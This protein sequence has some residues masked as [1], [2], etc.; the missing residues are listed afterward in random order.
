MS[1]FTVFVN[2]THAS[3]L[4]Y[5]VMEQTSNNLFLADKNQGKIYVFNNDNKGTLNKVITVGSA[6]TSMVIYNNYLLV[7]LSQAKKIKVIDTS[8]LTEVGEINT[9]K[10]PYWL[11]LDGDK[12][13]STVSRSNGTDY[14]PFIAELSIANNTVVAST[15]TVWPT[16]YPNFYMSGN[17]HI[18]VNP[19]THAAYIGNLGYSPDNIKKYDTSDINNIQYLMQN[20]HGSLGSNGQQFI[21][22]E[23]YSKIYFSASGSDGYAMQIV[24]SDNLTK[25]TDL[26]LGSYPNSV[27]YD[28]NYIYAGK[29]AYYNSGDIKVYNK[30]NNTFVKD[31]SLPDHENL[32]SKGISSGAN[33]YA[34]SNKYLYLLDKNSSKVTKIYD[35]VNN[36]VVD[37]VLVDTALK[38]GDL[39]KMENSSAI[40]QLNNNKRD[41]IPYGVGYEAYKGAILNS[42]SLNESSAKIISTAELTSYQLNKNLTI[43]PNANYLL[44][45]QNQERYYIVTSEATLTEVNKNNYSNFFLITIPDVFLPNYTIYDEAVP[46]FSLY[47]SKTGTGSGTVFEGTFL[48]M[49]SV[50]NCGD[51]CS[52]SFLPGAPVTLTASPASGSV[53][54]SW[55]GCG[56]NT[57]NPVC[58][59]QMNENKNIIAKFSP[60]TI[61][62]TASSPKIVNLQVAD[63]T[64]RPDRATVTWVTDV[65]TD[66]LVY[67]FEVGKTD[68]SWQGVDSLSTN[69]SVLIP[70]LKTFTTYRYYVNAKD[71]NGNITRSENKEFTTTTIS[72]VTNDLNNQKNEPVNKQVNNTTKTV[73]KLDDSIILKLQRKITELETKVIELEKRATQLDQKFANKYAGTM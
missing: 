70:D 52:A 1:L 17:E 29:S 30:A 41:V 33:L 26:S 21:F 19:V 24:N 35:F 39:I 11:A 10:M 56:S 72:P 7:A 66:S 55:T 57:T 38:D 58:T 48:E 6:P 54:T 43:K 31:Y 67:Y 59:V 27:A 40:Y 5:V 47:V 65:A 37:N 15:T 2:N 12:L 50:I 25:V 8:T 23:D 62:P 18:I 61:P 22:N 49:G 44:K 64:I 4:E 28:S 53:F 69:H 51:K 68:G 73:N 42:R 13:Y 9:S 3:E 45:K 36:K 46:S 16:T 34:A 71:A 14:Y 32:L 63:S 20:S 60:T